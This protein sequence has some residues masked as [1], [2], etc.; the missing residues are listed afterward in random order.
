MKSFIKALLKDF[1][2][3]WKHT[4]WTRSTYVLVILQVEVKTKHPKREEFSPSSHLIPL[5][6]PLAVPSW[7]WRLVRPWFS[8]SFSAGLQLTRE[9]R[10]RIDRSRRLYCI[11]S[12]IPSSDT[13]KSISYEGRLFVVLFLPS[14]HG[15]LFQPSV[16]FI[17]FHF[18]SFYPFSVQT[19]SSILGLSLH[20]LHL[21]FILSIF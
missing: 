18:L 10:R 20:L 6:S 21:N 8:W 1:P 7:K 2:W 17:S 16:P 11:F 3:L 5:S 9:R 14:P 15:T 12:E 13:A 4:H 19:F